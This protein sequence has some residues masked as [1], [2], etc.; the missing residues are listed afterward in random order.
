MLKRRTRLGMGP[1]Q[2]RYCA[3]VAA[4]IIERHTGRPA[5]EFSLFAPRVPIKPMC[6]TDLAGVRGISLDADD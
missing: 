5:D 1:C 6:I 2:G 4:S 3:P